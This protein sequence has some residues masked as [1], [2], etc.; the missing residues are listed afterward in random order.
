[1]CVCVYLYINNLIYALITR[2]YFVLLLIV[3]FSH[4]IWWYFCVQF[5]RKLCFFKDYFVNYV[6]EL[7]LNMTF[8]G[9]WLLTDISCNEP[10]CPSSSIM[11]AYKMIKWNERKQNEMK[12]NKTK[13]DV[14]LMRICP[15]VR[16]PQ[17][18][19][20]TNGWT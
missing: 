20:A 13:W 19:P 10:Y 4:F 14:V 8:W 6:P 18:E 3:L 5:S 17:N 2:M 1:M 9:S 11:V 7:S 16:L 15:S 12:W